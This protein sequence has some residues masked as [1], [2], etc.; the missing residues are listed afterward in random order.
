MELL[1]REPRLLSRRGQRALEPGLEQPAGEFCEPHAVGSR[2]IGELL[3]EFLFQAEGET[4]HLVEL[5]CV[6]LSGRSWLYY[7]WWD[8]VEPL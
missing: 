5:H 8:R 6:I 3:V 2:R 1:N 7:A 4:V